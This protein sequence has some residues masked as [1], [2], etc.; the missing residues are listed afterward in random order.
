MSETQANRSIR[1]E[2]SAVGSVIVSGDGNT[3]YV[4]QQT[5]KQR[6]EKTSQESTTIAPNPYKG[7][8]AFQESDVDRYFG[9]EDQVKRLWQ[10]FRVLYEQFDGPRVLPLLGASGCGKS[11][12][13]RAG[14]IPELAR[15]PLL[16]KASLRVAVLMPG[17]RPLEALAGVLAKAS[18]DDPLPVEK[19]KEFE[20]V[21]NQKNEA[22]E[23]DGLR[24]IS[25]M[26]PGIREM[27][28]LILVDQFEE[29]YSLCEN[30][31]QRQTFIDNLLHASSTPT[32]E[33]SVVMTL[34][35]DF[36]GETQ[37]HPLLNQIIGS[38]QSLI[39]PT[40]TPEELRQAIAIPAQKAEQPLD[41]AMVDLLIKDV[42]GHAGALPLLQFTL[43]RIWEGLAAGQKPISTYR[44][45]G[46][47]GGAL[48]QKA[49]EIYNG[50]DPTQQTITRRLFRSL[51]HFQEDSQ[52]VRSRLSESR[53]FSRKDDP[54]IVQRVINRFS[55][56]DVRLLT[57]AGHGQ[58]QTIEVTHEALFEH[59]PALTAWLK[60]GKL[61]IQEKQ[62]LEYAASEWKSSGEAQE[63]LL[64]G[65]RLEGA[66]H[67]IR[68]HQEEFSL[69]AVAS[70]YVT[71]SLYRRNQERQR[72][73]RIYSASA[74]AFISVAALSFW[75]IDN[76][77]RQ[78]QY[79]SQ[80]AII[81]NSTI[82]TPYQEEYLETA[83]ST[84]Q[85]ANKLANQGDILSRES[86]DE[87]IRY[88]R[89]VILFTTNSETLKASSNIDCQAA[90]TSVAELYCQAVYGLISTLEKSHFQTLSQQIQDN[91][92]GE[93]KPGDRSE[94]EALFS[95][96]ALQTTYS[97]LWRG[98]GIKADV[99]DGG[100]ISRLEAERIPC[101]FL[102]N[103]E[104]VW[105]DQ[106]D[107]KCGW[108]D[109]SKNRL[110]TDPDCD[111]L[112]NYT[113]T[114][115]VVEDIANSDHLVGRLQ[116][117]QLIPENVIDR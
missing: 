71:S 40:M 59:W 62:R 1:I 12:L 45:I 81:L 97:L 113:L 87:V 74:V 80:K 22:G 66:Q 86:L 30:A 114:T 115:R 112:T 109:R 35:S 69:S 75:F 7:L 76:A 19:A 10:R 20:R 52:Y 17:D 88:Y 93:F 21:L 78:S 105:I 70:D 16:G 43:F 29:V 90:N 6:R 8:A 39:V 107:N 18:T 49:Q 5:L 28:L 50:F 96:G 23:Y 13:A 106:T 91:Q 9:R 41:D 116:A 24:R 51:V 25:S 53:L 92:I 111:K 48:A 34:R 102:R 36:L 63:Y 110:F 103:L 85:E 55:Q 46:G 27:P 67:F 95:G 100:T 82:D 84:L 57:R 117:C 33:V 14:L 72:T 79:A 64:I 2:E 89:K 61:L 77:R 56:A 58:E 44:E 54:L 37:R 73:S 104:Q 42:A 60:D 32:R 108:Y 83:S 3:I 31:V 99:D 101:Q 38:D 11:S 65:K 15:H 68:Q 26:L 94:F 4:I 47:V 98:M